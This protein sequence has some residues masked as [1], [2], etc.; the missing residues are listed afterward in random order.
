MLPWQHRR[1]PLEPSDKKTLS[2]QRKMEKYNPKANDG[3]STD[4]SD[5]DDSEGDETN[6]PE[7]D[8]EN[9]LWRNDF[10]KRVFFAL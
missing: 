7:G 8:D 2:K 1:L 10:K 4:N 6:A 5:G 9:I 3:E